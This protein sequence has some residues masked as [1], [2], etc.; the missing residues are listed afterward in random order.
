VTVAEPR[1]ER[2]ALAAALGAAVGEPEPA[3]VV[4]LATYAPAAWTYALQCADRGAVIQFFAPAGPGERR[5]FAVDDVFFKELE[6]QASYSAGPRDTREA[7]RLIAAGDVTP[8]RLITHRF[9]LEETGAALAMARS[10]EGIKVI[11]TSA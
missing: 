2:R 4:L 10:R 9:A 1:P 8:E 7:L 6:I 11:V 3:T 5:D